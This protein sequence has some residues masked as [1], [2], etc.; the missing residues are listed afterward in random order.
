M[1][2]IEQLQSLSREHHQSLILAQKAI[3]VSAEGESS[4][5]A[6]LCQ[7]IVNEYN[8]VWRVHFQIEEESI[9]SLFK[10]KAEGNDSETEALQL[11]QQ[12]YQEH[13]T[14]N[15]YYEQMKS[16]EF[17]LLGVL[18]GKFGVLLKEH[19][20][21]EER[22]LFPLLEELLSSKELFE[23]FQTSRKYRNT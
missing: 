22:Q 12:L 15:D 18:L 9:F 19:T 10:N 7:D 13:Q 5:I 16:S 3:K 23:I 1:K 17:P 20:R 6:E 21:T 11:C 8:D 14:L 2:R 4:A